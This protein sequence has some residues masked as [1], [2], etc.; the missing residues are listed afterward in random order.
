MLAIDHKESAEYKEN[1]EINEEIVNDY[2]VKLD[3][4]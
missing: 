3:V 1:P 4:A 2:S